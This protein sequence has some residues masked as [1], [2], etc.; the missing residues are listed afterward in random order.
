M[1]SCCSFCGY[2]FSKE[3]IEYLEVAQALN[4]APIY[5]CKRCYNLAERFFEKPED[6]PK[7]GSYFRETPK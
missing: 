2:E 4:G 5:M 6:K 1:N 7:R 3:H